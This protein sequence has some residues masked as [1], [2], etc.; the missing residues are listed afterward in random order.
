M[1]MA[2][3]TSMS[4]SLAVARR[5]HTRTRTGL[6]MIPMPALYHPRALP[7][8]TWMARRVDVRQASTHMLMGLCTTRTMAL[9]RSLRLIRKATITRLTWM[10]HPLSRGMIT[11]GTATPQEKTVA[12]S[13]RVVACFP[14]ADIS[15]GDTEGDRMVKPLCLAVATE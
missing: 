5:V 7:S 9:G 13:D 14:P 3:D 1:D 2:M 15:E 8:L 6:C 12:A 10:L 11:L 4:R